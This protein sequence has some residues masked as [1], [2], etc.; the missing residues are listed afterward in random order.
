MAKQFDMLTPDH[1]TFILRQNIFFTASGTSESR[2]NV[3]PREIEALRI[4]DDN[5]VLYLDRTGS[6]NETA[7][8]MLADGW[9]PLM[10]CAFSGPPQVM[11]LYGKGSAI[12]WN[13]EEFTQLTAQYYDGNTPLG[14]RQIMKIEFDF[15]QTSCGYGVPLFEYQ[16]ERAAIENWHN[17]KGAD[18]IQ[19]YWKEKNISSMDDLPAGLKLECE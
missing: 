17:G 8:H 19:A 10:F 6:G 4:V 9:I 1:R 5:A 16:G 18:G 2:V 14:T 11:R 12:G 15:L 3:S 13:R 7:A